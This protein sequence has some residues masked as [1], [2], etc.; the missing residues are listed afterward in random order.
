M[1]MYTHDRLWPELSDL[2][3][4]IG[5]NCHLLAASSGGNPFDEVM[6]CPWAALQDAY[7]GYAIPMACKSTTIELRGQKDVNEELATQDANALYRFLQRRGF[8]GIPTGSNLPPLP[9]LIR[10]AS[11]LDGVDM[12]EASKVG[13]V[14]WKVRPGDFVQEDQLLGEIIDIED[15]D[16]V[17][18]PIVSRTAGIVFGMR[19]D[20][21]VNPGQI[22][23]KIAGAQSLHWRRGHLLTA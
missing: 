5:S 8:I 19:Q 4:E 7:P 3:A 2:A 20:R 9:A 1:H 13:V 16:A 11:P 14:A 23:I 22:I 17:R 15:V 6:S 21:L 10:E 18:L 12:I